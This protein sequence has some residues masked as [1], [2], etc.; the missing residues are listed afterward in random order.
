M[1]DTEFLIISIIIHDRDNI[2]KPVHGTSEN[3]IF[4]NV[5]VNRVGQKTNLIFVVDKNGSGFSEMVTK[6]SPCK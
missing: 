2:F 5:D 6:V 4:T 3:I 1:S